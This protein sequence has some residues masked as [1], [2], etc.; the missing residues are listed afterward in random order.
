MRLIP[1]LCL[2]CVSA[3]SPAIASGIFKQ[4]VQMDFEVAYKKVYAALEDNRFFVIDEID[5]AN[6]LERF[7]DKWEDFNLNKLEQQKIMIICNGWY[8]NQVGNADTDMLALCPMRVTLLHK[9]GMTTVLFAKPSTF[10]TNSKALPILTEIETTITG[11]I[12]K[13]LN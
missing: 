10:A 2:L 9:D 13:A 11:A 12:D 8:A 7:K 4:S 5:M 1:L 6:S 3:I